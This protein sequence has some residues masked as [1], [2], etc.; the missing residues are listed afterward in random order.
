MSFGVIIVWYTTE[1]S[2]IIGADV[3]KSGGLRSLKALGFEKW[4]LE[5]SSLT[6]VYAYAYSWEIGGNSPCTLMG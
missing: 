4:G 6:E 1:D 3:A 5:P 2:F